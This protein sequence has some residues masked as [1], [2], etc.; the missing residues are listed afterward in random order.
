MKNNKEKTA[1]SEKS[2]RGLSSPRNKT[3]ITLTVVTLVL[4]AGIATTYARSGAHFTKKG[5]YS[6]ET[7]EA[8]KEAFD[9]HDYQ[10]W[11]ELM[12]DRP[13]V[14][15]INGADFTKLVEAHELRQQ[16][17]FQEAK[18]IM[19]ELGV[20]HPGAKMHMKKG[21]HYSPERKEAVKT[22]LDNND[23]AAWLKAVGEDSPMA[24]KIN[25]NN[26][27]RLVEA[28]GLIEQGV[29]IMQELGIK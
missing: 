3:L 4:A 13:I 20:K 25:E 14:D 2:Q 17:D 24:E 26:F 12:Q 8:V 27:P 29:K 10:A 18:T 5:G 21:L 6:A 16:G 7:Q 1:S 23:Y 11:L 28:H 9:N 15:K 19:K 22:A